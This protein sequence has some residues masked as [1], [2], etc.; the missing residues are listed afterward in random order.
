[1][2][3]ITS[4][5]LDDGTYPHDLNKTSAHVLQKIALVPKQA[6]NRLKIKCEL[7]V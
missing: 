1:M 3:A 7:D 4:R 6:E 5:P 2:N